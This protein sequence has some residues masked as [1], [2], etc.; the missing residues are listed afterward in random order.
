MR[1]IY[2]KDIFYEGQVREIPKGRSHPLVQLVEAIESP[3]RR[4]LTTLSLFRVPVLRHRLG[5]FSTA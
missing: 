1:D 2:A 4:T 5:V 3:L